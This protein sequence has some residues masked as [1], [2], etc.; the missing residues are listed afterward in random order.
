MNQACNSLN[1]L[2]L[3]SQI[4]NFQDMEEEVADKE[5]KI[6]DENDEIIEQRKNDNSYIPSGENSGATHPSIL[7]PLSLTGSN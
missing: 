4:K 3:E 1:V 5:E 7:P 2:S 6:K